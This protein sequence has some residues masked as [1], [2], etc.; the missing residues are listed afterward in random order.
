M[1]RKLDLHTTTVFDNFDRFVETSG[2]KV[3][4]NDTVGI[5][6][7]DIH[8]DHS[9]GTADESNIMQSQS[10]ADS[11]VDASDEYE[12][13]NEFLNKKRRRS[14]KGYIAELQPYS[15]RPRLI[16]RM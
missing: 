14:Y 5:A 7:Q 11:I 2:N 9:Q 16:E 6:V 12:E 13:P 4:M 8:V 10:L 15:K 3:T 1:V